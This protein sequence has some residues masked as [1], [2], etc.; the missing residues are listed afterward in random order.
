MLGGLGI[1]SPRGAWA[2]VYSPGQSVPHSTVPHSTV[3]G[4]TLDVF[5]WSQNAAHSTSALWS[6]FDVLSGG[7]A[8]GFLPAGSSPLPQSSFNNGTADSSLTFQ[9]NQSL[10]ASGNAYGGLFGN[11]DDSSFLTDAFLIVR[12]GVSGG[13]FTRIVV[14]FETLGSELDYASIL[15]S[16]SIET[17]GI[18]APSLALETGRTSLGGFGGEGVSYLAMWD[19]DSSQEEYRLDFRASETHMSLDTLRVDSFT[20]SVPF[21]ETTTV[22]EPSSWLS[23]GGL[24]MAISRRRRRRHR[25]R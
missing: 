20:Q 10:P 15:L 19:L 6:R 16:P 18:L 9:S 23:I 12:S 17:A 25:R 13:D 3:P 22:P 21:G 24:F 1:G 5:P 8:T 2:V 7:T 11:G 4:T 14:Q